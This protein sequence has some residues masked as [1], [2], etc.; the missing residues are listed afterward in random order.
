MNVIES[1]QNQMKEE[2]AAKETEADEDGE[3]E[4]ADEEQES[5]T[6]D[7]TSMGENLSS[8]VAEDKEKCDVNAEIQVKATGDLKEEILKP[9][10][11]EVAEDKENRDINA[12]IQDKAN[13]DPS[14]E[15]LKPDE[16]EI[17]EKLSG[18]T[19][20]RCVSKRKK[21]GS[22]A[23][24]AAKADKPKRNYKRKKTGGN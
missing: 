23:E 10:E 5:D 16:K 8:D 17:D 15:I 11:K 6:V 19:K 7:S 20:G 21:A 3:G 12:E 13:C 1:L 24:D 14:D 2:E 4:A 9:D 18:D 22:G